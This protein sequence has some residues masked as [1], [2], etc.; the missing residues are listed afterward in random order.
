MSRDSLNHRSFVDLIAED[1]QHRVGAN[2]VATPTRER[3]LSD[4]F[5][6]PE[7]VRFDEDMPGP[8]VGCF[9]TVGCDTMCVAPDTATPRRD[10]P[11]ELGDNANGGDKSCAIA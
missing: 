3:E 10:A 9:S 5:A 2:V 7:G 6:S 8:S 4:E 1:D 11:T